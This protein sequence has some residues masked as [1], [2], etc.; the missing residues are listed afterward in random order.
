[1]PTSS[2]V[3]TLVHTVDCAHYPKML[4]AW[5]QVMLSDIRDPPSYLTKLA[6][7]ILGAKISWKHT[8]NYTLKLYT[9]GG[10]KDILSQWGVLPKSR[11][12]STKFPSVKVHVE[13]CNWVLLTDAPKLKCI[14][15]AKTH[16]PTC[17]SCLVKHTVSWWYI[18]SDQIYHKKLNLVASLQ[19]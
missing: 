19:H 6:T 11:F 18:G 13:I 17:T 12:A 5:K 7:Y 9:L 10:S 2:L 8:R 16:C 3:W 1:M 14:L 4:L 15:P